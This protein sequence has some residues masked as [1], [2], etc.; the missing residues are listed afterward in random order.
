MVVGLL[1]ECQEACL[2][3][4]PPLGV[5]ER[6]GT[7]RAELGG[8]RGEVSGSEVVASWHMTALM[9]ERISWS[10]GQLVTQWLSSLG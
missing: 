6:V 3:V 2:Y 8:D 9:R 5:G 1:L 10:W 7:L 4:I